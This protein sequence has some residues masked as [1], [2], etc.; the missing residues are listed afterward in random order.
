MKILNKRWET[1]G[2]VYVEMVEKKGEYI[3]SYLNTYITGIYYSKKDNRLYF[4]YIIKEEYIYKDETVFIYTE[5]TDEGIYYSNKNFTAKEEKEKIFNLIEDIELNVYEKEQS[6]VITD[7]TKI[8]K[9]EKY[10]E[11]Y[12]KN[13]KK[14][15]ENMEVYKVNKS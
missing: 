7:K 4:N 9:I 3:K 12:E 14:L 2:E 15:I 10:I 1:Q 6:E 11:K 5:E 8:K 13:L